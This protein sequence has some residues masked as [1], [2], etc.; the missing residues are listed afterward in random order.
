MEES[1][2]DKI[3]ILQRNIEEA[4][5]FLALKFDITQEMLGCFRRPSYEILADKNRAI[6]DLDNARFNFSINLINDTGTLGEEASH[7]LH[8]ESN[9]LFFQDMQDI[10]L[11]GNKKITGRFLKVNNLSELIGYYGSLVYCQIKGVSLEFRK[12]PFILPE[13]EYWDQKN[14]FDY[15][16]HEEGYK[17]AQEAISRYGD[18]LLPRLVNMSVEEAI[19]TV[20]RLLP[21]GFYERKVLPLLD[22][23]RDFR[24]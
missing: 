17:R 20:P 10:F 1:I 9:P 3:E 13:G 11:R 12:F 2:D 16:G 15:F 23:F 24:I 4:I 19:R 8:A 7:Y 5:E 6:F 22:R 14:L 18:S 21:I